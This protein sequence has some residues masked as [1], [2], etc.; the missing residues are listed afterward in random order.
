M[1]WI[2]LAFF[3]VAALIVWYFYL[4]WHFIEGKE[5]SNKTAIVTRDVFDALPVNGGTRSTSV[6]EPLIVLGPTTEAAQ[7][8]FTKRIARKEGLPY[9]RE[10]LSSV[11]MTLD[12]IVESLSLGLKGTVKKSTVRQWLMEEKELEFKK[13][14]W[15]LK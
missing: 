6:E 9:I 12:E 2:V 11:P 13:R 10:I 4:R 5:S 7:S 1:I 3:T 14:K 8:S 15:R